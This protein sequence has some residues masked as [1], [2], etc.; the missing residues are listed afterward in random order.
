[1]LGVEKTFIF[2]S[3][4]VYTSSFNIVI[5]WF[6]SWKAIPVFSWRRRKCSCLPQHDHQFTRQLES[7]RLTSSKPF[8]ER[9]IFFFWCVPQCPPP[10]EKRIAKRIASKTTGDLLSTD[11]GGDSIQQNKNVRIIFQHETKCGTSLKTPGPNHPIMSLTPYMSLA[12]L[13]GMTQFQVVRW[14][15]VAT[16]VNFHQCTIFCHVPHWYSL[17][18]FWQ[19][20]TWYI[21]SLDP[22]FR[23]CFAMLLDMFQLRTW[24]EQNDKYCNYF[25]PP[26]I[27]NCYL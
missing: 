27:W 7:W 10:P 20:N 15:Q 13:F 26:R 23:T 19:G 4:G 1:M 24:V 17:L 22:F 8:P 25:D 21:R 3:F 5:S 6:S 9:S 2:H 12:D 14:G 11:L 18:D 16:L